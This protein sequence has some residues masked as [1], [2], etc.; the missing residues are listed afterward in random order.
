M[1]TTTWTG[2]AADG[3]ICNAANWDNGLPD[4]TV[5]A[6]IGGSD[7]NLACLTAPDY[8]EVLTLSMAGFTGSVGNVAAGN[9][10]F[11]VNTSG[12]VTLSAGMT[13]NNDATYGAMFNIQG[14][15]SFTL[16]SAGK[17]IQAVSMLPGADFTLGD[18]LTLDGGIGLGPTTDFHFS[19]YTLTL[20]PHA[21]IN[22][23]FSQGGAVTYG[24][25]AKIVVQLDVVGTYRLIGSLSVPLPEV[26]A[27][28]TVAAVFSPKDIKTDSFSFDGNNVGTL[29]VALDLP[30]VECVGAATAVDATIV[31]MTFTDT[32]L[33]A[34]D[35]CVDGGGNTNVYFGITT[36]DTGAGDGLWSTA[37]N[38]TFGVPDATVDAVIIGA[39]PAELDVWEAPSKSL[40]FSAYTGEWNQEDQGNNAL[41]YGDLIFGDGMTFKGYTYFEF[42]ANGSFTRGS[43]P[44]PPNGDLE[45]EASAGAVVTITDDARCYSLLFNGGATPHVAAAGVLHLIGVEALSGGTMS[46]ASGLTF[47]PG[48]TIEIE[49]PGTQVCTAELTA[50]TGTN[51][52]PISVDSTGGAVVIQ[53]A[54]AG[55][56]NTP[57]FDMTGAGTAL[58]RDTKLVVAGAAAAAD[59]EIRDCTFAGGTELDASDNC[60][61]G[62]GNTNVSFGA[63]G[64]PIASRPFLAPR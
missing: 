22:N 51:L 14:D 58:L 11:N 55:S 17:R 49:S 31:G 64:S 44:M 56:M 18:N 35:N 24:A 53:S 54:T 43:C 3:D 59:S 61:D 9:K 29:G 19:T 60:V 23:D 37:G 36:W 8:I 10:F 62:L 46:L 15:A 40:D 48:A 13:V 33:D 32:T 47:D 30:T 2:G 5:D 25:G 16:V 41:V 12:N 42:K 63:V 52:P 26:E 57:S 27:V 34:T 20:D 4:S 21:E 45:I 6:V 50:P 38:W 1:P 39:G 28:A 7:A